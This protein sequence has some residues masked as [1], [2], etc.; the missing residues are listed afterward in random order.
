MAGRLWEREL[1]WNEHSRGLISR[2]GPDAST[3]QGGY[4]LFQRVT[5]HLPAFDFFRRG[6]TALV[7]TGPGWRARI[8][9]SSFS[10]VRS[11]R[12]GV[13]ETKLF[14]KAHRSVPSSS[15]FNGLMV[16]Q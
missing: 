12:R 8:R 4:S 2:G 11:R 14:A 10:S 5:C 3:Q 9:A 7:V 1:T 13:M 15:P 16:N 6:E